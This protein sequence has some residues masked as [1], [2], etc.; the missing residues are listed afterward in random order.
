MTAYTFLI[1]CQPR[2]QGGYI[3]TARSPDQTTAGVGIGPT[4]DSSIISAV[5]DV[6]GNLRQRNA[7]RTPVLRSLPCPVCDD[8]IEEK[9]PRCGKTPGAA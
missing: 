4:E 1:V 2:A 9:C 3:A 5:A 7:H 6:L 8:G